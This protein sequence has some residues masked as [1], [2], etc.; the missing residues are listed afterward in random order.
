[1]SSADRSICPQCC[2]TASVSGWTLA[3]MSSHSAAAFSSPLIN[4]TR[5]GSAESVMA[6]DQGASAGTSFGA[7]PFSTGA[8]RNA[9]DDATLTLMS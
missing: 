6:V 8:G 4:A 7:E 3:A 2:A 5:V 9:G 1:M